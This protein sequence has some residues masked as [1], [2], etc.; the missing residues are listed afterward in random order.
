VTA[1]AGDMSAR[2]ATVG[3][4]G[5]PSVP[6]GRGSVRALV[7]ELAR[8][9]FY[10]AIFVVVAAGVSFL[11]TLLLP[12]E[13]TQR[14]SFLNWQFLTGRLLAWSVVLGVG[15]GVVVA[16]Q[17][18]TIRRI[19]AARG[20]A[21]TGFA[22][23]GA[24]LPSLLCCSPIIPT[25]LSFVGLSTVSVY[26]LSGTFQHFFAVHQNQFLAGS[27][28]LL[29]ISGWWGLTRAARSDCWNDEGCAVT[30]A[31]DCCTAAVKSPDDIFDEAELGR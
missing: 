26:S 19:M 16:V 13:Y 28:A 31:D 14:F 8:S 29:V 12:Y 27:L 22:L 10:L 9:P 30:P 17:V 18:A 4:V 1:T 2:D 23:V 15:M 11:Y 25:V 21:L 20:S 6:A 3:H 5:P 7:G 24:V